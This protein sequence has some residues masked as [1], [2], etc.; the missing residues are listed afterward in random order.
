MWWQRAVHCSWRNS[1]FFLVS[2][3]KLWS[4]H[5]QTWHSKLDLVCVRNTKSWRRYCAY[6]WTALFG[7]FHY[8]SIVITI[9]VL[10]H[11]TFKRDLFL[12]LMLLDKFQGLLEYLIIIII[13][14]IIILYAMFTVII[15]GIVHY[16]CGD[17]IILVP[18]KLLVALW[19]THI[20]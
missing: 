18:A 3:W 16:C 9:I 1:L 19:K 12:C 20:A 10:N 4:G 15:I 17:W 8:R 2:L 7:L 11:M 5:T 6:H 13:I 14:I